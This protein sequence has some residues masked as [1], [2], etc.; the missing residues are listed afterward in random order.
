MGDDIA[1]IDGWTKPLGSNYPPHD[2][3][4]SAALVLLVRG[5]IIRK[6]GM[7]LILLNHATGNTY[8]HGSGLDSAPIFSGRLGADAAYYGFDV[9]R[10]TV[11]ANVQNY[12]FILHEAPGRV[13]FGLD[14]A[15]AAVRRDRFDYKGANLPFPL[16]LLDR[17]PRKPLLPEHLKT[18]HSPPVSIAKWDELSWSHMKL[19]EARY[20]NVI[21]TYPPVTEAP[22]Y[23]PTGDARDSAKIARSF[24]QK[25]VAAILPARRVLS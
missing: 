6:F 25:P 2:K 14:V 12:F 23:W 5:D 24:W 13:R 1:P 18:G 7:I 22:N 3:D 11:L 19:D 15:T 4:R 9:S 10:D 8:V 17:D 20:I 16:K 21:T